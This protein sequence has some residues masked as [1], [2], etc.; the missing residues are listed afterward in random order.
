MGAGRKLAFLKIGANELTH[1][2]GDLT[3]NNT[4]GE[5]DIKDDSDDYEASIPGDNKVT[6]TGSCNYQT[7]LPTSDP[8]MQSIMNSLDDGEI[9]QVTYGYEKATGE[10][11]YTAEGAY[12]TSYN[13]A[14]GDPQTVSFNI[15]VGQ[16]PVKSDQA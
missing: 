12:C 15:T 9:F 10:K 2:K 11:Q 5:I 13:I 4:R 3:I 1:T 16:K 6:I 7:T 14:K 8:A